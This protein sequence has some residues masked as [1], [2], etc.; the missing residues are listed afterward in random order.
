MKYFYKARLLIVT[1]IEFRGFTE[2]NTFI[3]YEPVVFA[4]PLLA[5]LIRWNVD[6][7]RKS[8]LSRNKAS[9]VQ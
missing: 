8:R 1:K 2:T 4:P 5:F 7:T 6:D 9:I 3:D